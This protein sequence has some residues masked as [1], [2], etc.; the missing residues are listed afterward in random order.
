MANLRDKVFKI[1]SKNAGPFTVTVDIFCRNQTNLKRILGL[2][3]GDILSRLY[4]VEKDNFE[5]FEV[6]DLNVMKISFPR[7]HIQGSRLDRDMHGAQFAELL[8]EME[9]PDNF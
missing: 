1:R 4:N 8:N 6:P 2:L 3:D 5:I 7:T 9:L